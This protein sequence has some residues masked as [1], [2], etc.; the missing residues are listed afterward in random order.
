MRALSWKLISAPKFVIDYV[1][2]HD[3]IHTRISRHT[4]R[5]WVHLAAI[6]QRS[7]EA[8]P[9]LQAHRPRESSERFVKVGQ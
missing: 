5:F 9:W 1:I 7:L 8:I 3:L 2:L 6:C 4:Q